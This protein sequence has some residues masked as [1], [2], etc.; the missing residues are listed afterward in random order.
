MTDFGPEYPKVQ[1]AFLRDMTVKGSPVLP[2]QWTLPEFAY[3]ADKPWRW[4]EK[5]D[6]TNTRLHFD[7]GQVTL[8]GRT[9]NAQV[10]AHLIDAVRRLGLLDVARWQEKFPLV[11]FD[12]GVTVYGEGYGPKIQKGGGLYRDDVSFI[13]FDVRVG[14]WWLQPD[15]VEDVASFLGLETVPY[16]GDGTP[17]DVWN[18]IMDGALIS[19]WQDRGVRIE[20]LVGTPAVP[21]YDRRGHRLVMKLKVRDAEDFRRARGDA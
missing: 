12:G 16:W 11:P 17:R 20:G 15:A 21:L 10:P 14:D 8:G 19:H 13:V 5:V 1:T 9:G 2:G 7:G 6:G 4:T 18:A 3:L